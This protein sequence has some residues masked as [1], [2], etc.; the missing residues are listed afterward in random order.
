MRSVTRHVFA[1]FVALLMS[2]CTSAL[3]S[4]H[5]C[6]QD[7][8]KILAL[9][10]DA[11]TSA[12]ARAEQSVV[13]IARIRKERRAQDR[14]RLAPLRLDAPLD[15]NDP[16]QDPDFVPRF[17]GSGVIISEDGFIV[18]CAHL[19]GDPKTH[20][21]H[22]WLNRQH[23]RATVVSP[24][25]AAVAYA[26]DPFSDLAV[27][28]IQAS[29]L[30][31]IEFAD[32]SQLKKGKFV[33]ALGN[34]DAIARDGAASA[35]WG[36]ISNLSRLAPARQ[37]DEGGSKESVHRYG[38][39]IQ[40]DARTTVGTSGGALVDL[41]G[42][43][44][45]LTTSLRSRQDSDDSGGFAIATDE[46]FRRVVESLK[47]GKLPEYGFLGVQPEP[48]DPFDRER[49]IRGVR[50]GVVIPGFPGEKAGLRQDD[51][52]SDVDG[53]P[54]DNRNELFR[55][56]ST[57]MAG[58]PVRLNVLRRANSRSPQRLVLTA[59][60]SKKPLSASSLGYALHVD[61][62]WNGMVVDYASAIPSELSRLGLWRSGSQ[63]PEIAVRG[64]DPD[65]PAWQ[66]G[67]RP[68]V[69][70][71]SV[72]GKSV[73]TPAEFYA[74]VQGEDD[75]TLSLVNSDGRAIQVALPAT[76]VENR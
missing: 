40:T 38:T 59:T 37:D 51:I 33:I 35:S 57:T 28:K 24:P 18:T 58:E 14:N 76:S 21:Y 75:C 45:G 30:T 66:A 71:L 61:G 23:Y 11:T 56:L 27:L 1:G 6:A 52:V 31:P 54:V 50:I 5:A 13:A 4:S 32:T 53:K 10:E 48:I 36:I 17:F 8:T 20:D 64:V 44:L 42:K 62:G 25:K 47:K 19:L 9:V 43:M 67:L 63:S 65:T 7:A 49:G 3:H 60:V 29:G 12:I 69:G 72:N 68:G 46:L 70:I 15:L 22:V 34:P 73:S 16:I 26:S 39:L 2:Q 41:D 55:E 74:A